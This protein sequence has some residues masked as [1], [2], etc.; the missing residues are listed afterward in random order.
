[1]SC[2][3][4]YKRQPV[5]GFGF[6]PIRRDAL[7]GIRGIAPEQLLDSGKRHVELAHHRDQARLFDLPDLVIAIA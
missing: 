2:G 4:V 3:D 1:M 6:L 5:R 7:G